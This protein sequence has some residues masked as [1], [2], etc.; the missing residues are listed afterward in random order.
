MA[1][2]HASGIAAL[3][4]GENGG[5]M[6]PAQ[7][8]AEMAARSEDLGQAGK[9]RVRQEARGENDITVDNP[10]IYRTAITLDIPRTVK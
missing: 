10:G 3:I 8:K 7:V 9:D 5:S 2:P 6:H 4:I 1:T